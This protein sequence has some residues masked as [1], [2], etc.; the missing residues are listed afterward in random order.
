M[1]FLDGRTLPLCIKPGIKY[2]LKQYL[3]NT[4]ICAREYELKGWSATQVALL[5]LLVPK[6]WLFPPASGPEF[7]PL[8]AH[9]W[10]HLG[11]PLK[12]KHFTGKEKPLLW[13]P[14]MCLPICH[15]VCSLTKQ[16]ASTKCLTLYQVPCWT[17]C[18]ILEI[19]SLEHQP[20]LRGVGFFQLVLKGFTANSLSIYF[21]S[22]F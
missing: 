4:W 10:G 20:D 13:S 14:Y 9:R 8:Q 19:L 21:L 16:W 18:P 2:V 6:K 15:S 12:C 17:H 22:V 3:L 1:S 11:T 7:P 5:I